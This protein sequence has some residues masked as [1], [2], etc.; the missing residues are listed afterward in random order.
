MASLQDIRH[1]IKSV[2]S[3][4]QITSAMNMVATSRLRRAKEAANANRP[5]AEKV[6][7]VVR[8]IA[9]N[10]G[11]DFRHPLLETH[12]TGKRLILVMTADKGLAGAYTSN[13]CKA[14][15]ALIEDKDNTQLIVVG[16]RGTTHFRSRGFDVVNSY[17]GVSD[18]PDFE[19]ARRIAMEL[20]N[21]F[22]TGEVKEVYMVYTQFISA[23]S[24]EARSV[25]LLPFQNVET[26]EA[27]IHTEYIYE[28]DAA[29]VLGFLLPQYLYTTVYASML[30]AAASEVSS[31]MNA[32]SN[33][34]DNAD[35]LMHK[36]DLYY[37][38]VRQAGIT[39][40]LTEIVGGAAALE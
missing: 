29:T 3:T 15:H 30:Q 35:D 10:A 17:L 24:C 22:K 32:M 5:Y 36:L 14:A 19:T 39:T 37:N 40:E 38:K 6:V 11:T 25:Q 26:R 23:I 12:A 18:R 28:P 27:G 8:D 20:I 33:A 16:R 21:R 4:R 1:R 13:A 2:K 34:T 7:E 9:A 31:R